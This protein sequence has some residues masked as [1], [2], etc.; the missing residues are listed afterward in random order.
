MLCMA[1]R[2]SNSNGTLVCCIGD[3]ESVNDPVRNGNDIITERMDVD[4]PIRRRKRHLGQLASSSSSS[5]A[6]AAAAPGVTGKSKNAVMLLN[7]LQP[8]GLRYHDVIKSGPDHKPIYTASV[9]VYG[10]VDYSF[11]CR[12]TGIGNYCV[13]WYN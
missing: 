4:K 9:T 10:Q 3:A 8:A 7:E 1:M 13:R 5:S 11:T 2:P 12:T 6:A